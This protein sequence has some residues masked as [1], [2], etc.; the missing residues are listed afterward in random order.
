MKKIFVLLLLFVI[1]SCKSDFD[2]DN[3]K[4]EIHKFYISNRDKIFCLGYDLEDY[5]KILIDSIKE[6]PKHIY[7]QEKI[8]FQNQVMESY[9]KVKEHNLNLYYEV[10]KLQEQELDSLKNIFSKTDKDELYYKCYFSYPDLVFSNLI[11]LDGKYKPIECKLSDVGDVG[12]EI[13]QR[14]GNKS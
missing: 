12:V 10:I 14:K 3:L 9:I 2:K 5:N 11:M 8:E 13:K 1:S 7:L 6:Y 4:F